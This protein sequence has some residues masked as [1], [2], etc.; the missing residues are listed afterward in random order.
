M[1]ARIKQ[2]FSLNGNLIERAHETTNDF[3]NQKLV[4]STK[5]KQNFPKEIY[6][7]IYIVII[8]ILT[9]R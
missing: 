2:A 8:T 9:I 4:E 7:Y 5:T 1:L 3:I 6:I